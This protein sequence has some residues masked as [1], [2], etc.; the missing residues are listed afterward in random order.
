MNA[1]EGSNSLPTMRFARAGSQYVVFLNAGRVN[2]P[3]VD[4]GISDAGY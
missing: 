4:G 3:S 2:S 1:G